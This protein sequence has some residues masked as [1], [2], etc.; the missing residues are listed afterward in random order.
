MSEVKSY[1]IGV[2]D[3]DDVLLNAI[4][5]LRSQGAKILEAFTPFAVHGIDPALGIK[6]SRLPQAAFMFGATGTT[7]ALTLMITTLGFDWPMNI[8]GKPHLPFPSFIPISFELTVLFTA[9][10]MVTTFLLASGLGPGASKVIFDPRSS[11]DKFI[12]VFELDK[13]KQFTSDQ[14]A[15]IVKNS[16]ASEVNYKD[17]EEKH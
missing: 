14:L 8:G 16:G 12:L 15:Q 13:N 17:L 6:R 4:H 7:C 10:G 2:Y 3:D 5:S 1:L 9:I 11:D